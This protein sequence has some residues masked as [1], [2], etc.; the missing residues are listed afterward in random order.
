MVINEWT[1]GKCSVKKRSLGRRE[2]KKII[3]V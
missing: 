3:P 2:E 1:F